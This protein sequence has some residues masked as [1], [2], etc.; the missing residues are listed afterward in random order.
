M[1]H[2]CLFSIAICAIIFTLGCSSTVEPLEERIAKLENALKTCK[3]TSPGKRTGV[4]VCQYLILIHCTNQNQNFLNNPCS[5]LYIIMINDVYAI[6]VLIWCLEKIRRHG[7]HV[8]EVSYVISC[9]EN[10]SKIFKRH[11]YA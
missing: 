4:C 8:H 3:T 9:Q 10:R 6:Q 7:I 11:A 5:W 1:S 2:E